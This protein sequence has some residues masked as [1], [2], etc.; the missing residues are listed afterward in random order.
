MTTARATLSVAG[1]YQL[2]DH[3]G[4]YLGGST[5]V[6]FSAPVNATILKLRFDPG[7]FRNVGFGA[8]AEHGENYSFR[9]VLSQAGIHRAS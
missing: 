4:W 2:P 9:D 6:V 8:V 5:R 7:P 3:N 1:P